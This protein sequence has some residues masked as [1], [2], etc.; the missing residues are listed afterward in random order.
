MIFYPTHSPNCV[1]KL[2][3]LLNIFS[4]NSSNVSA[5]WM[6]SDTNAIHGRDKVIWN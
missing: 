6:S 2:S 1:Y 4:S 3:S 5:K